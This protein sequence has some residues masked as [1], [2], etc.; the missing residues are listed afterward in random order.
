MKLQKH[1]IVWNLFDFVNAIFTRIVKFL[2]DICIRLTIDSKY[3]CPNC[4]ND[5]YERVEYWECSNKC[6]LFNIYR[7]IKKTDINKNMGTGSET[8]G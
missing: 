3:C 5:V 7:V 6:G 8:I 2:K 4:H 1:V